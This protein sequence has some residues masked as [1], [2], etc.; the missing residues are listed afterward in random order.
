M[1]QY[2]SWLAT[3][4]Q[5][6]FDLIQSQEFISNFELPEQED[7]EPLFVSDP[8]YNNLNSCA[9]VLAALVSL[10]RWMSVSLLIK[11]GFSFFPID[12]GTVWFERV[13]V[14]FRKF[15][16]KT[17]HIFENPLANL[18]PLLFCSAFC[19]VLHL[20]GILVW[21]ELNCCFCAYEQ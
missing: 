11:F 13:L 4:I 9:F 7:E 16:S 18:V 20:N 15:T 19:S 2:H 21:S 5:Y 10:P 12:L 17:V 14:G 3:Y 6:I 1:Y 8:V